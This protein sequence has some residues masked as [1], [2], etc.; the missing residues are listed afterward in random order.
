MVSGYPKVL[1]LSTLTAQGMACSAPANGNAV[2]VREVVPLN[3]IFLRFVGW[4]TIN[5]AASSTASAAGGPNRPPYNIAIIIDTTG[6]MNTKDSD[7]NCNTTRISCALSGVQTLLQGLTPC[8][9]DK[10]SATNNCG[11]ADATGNYS[12]AMDRVGIYTFP[13]LAS[14]TD[15]AYEYDCSTSTTPHLSNYTDG[16]NMGQN[17]PQYKVLDYSSD[18]KLYNGAALNPNSN[19]VRL[20]GGG[21]SGC[22][23]M[24]AGLTS[25][26]NRYCC[27][28][29]ATGALY[30]AGIDLIN[31]Q[32]TYPN[33]ESVAIVLTDGDMNQLAS[34]NGTNLGTMPNASNSGNYPSY[35]NECQQLI[36]IA[37][38][39]AYYKIQVYTV[40][41]GAA[42]SGCSTD[43][44]KLTPCQ[45][46]EAIASAPQY[47]Y[48][49]YTATGASSNCISASHPTTGLSSIFQ[50]IRANFAVPRL[51]PDNTS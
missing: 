17:V 45:T 26:T 30:A 8:A 31:L 40:A 23:P 47:F 18:Y 42:A 49:D 27:S 43:N 36:N 11:T 16:P 9:P 5:I 44:G 12:S 21:T 15:A 20:L 10:T 46:V 38:Y 7:S 25:T 6:S 28:T 2:Q 14:S 24:Q 13:A 33:S 50:Q 34:Y 48:S 22:G 35:V 4:S 41:Y 3:L 51:I 1:C 29:Y 37:S 19:L 39:A 32:S